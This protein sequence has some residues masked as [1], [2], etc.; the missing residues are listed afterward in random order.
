[1][2]PD[3]GAAGTGLGPEGGA[4]GGPI[5]LFD[6]GAGETAVTDAD[7]TA[8]VPGLYVP[9]PD[10]EGG[11]ITDYTTVAGPTSSTPFPVAPPVDYAVGRVPSSAVAADLNGD[12]KVDLVVGTYFSGIQVLLNSG[13]GAFA[14]P[15]SYAT[16]PA[17]AGALALGD[18][19]GDGKPDIVVADGDLWVFVNDGK[20]SFVTPVA[21]VNR[22]PG[23]ASGFPAVGDFDKDGKAD[24]VVYSGAAAAGAPEQATVLL[25]QGGG[26][27]AMPV[28][29]PLGTSVSG[30]ILAD[31]DGDGCLD[32]VVSNLRDNSVSFGKNACDGSAKLGAPLTWRTGGPASGVAAGVLATRGNLHPD[33]VAS[34]SSIADV[35]VFANYLVGGG[36]TFD[37]NTAVRYN[38]G[39]G[40]RAVA[41]ADVDGDGDQ[42]VVVSL[43]GG[44]GV[45][46]N[47]GD[48][49]FA[50]PRVALS[51]CGSKESVD[52]API[53]LAVADFDGD[54][55]P[56][57]AATSNV[58]GVVTVYLNR[59]K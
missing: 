36:P 15:V 7:T 24:I 11:V 39:G 44:V 2:I 38:A 8:C 58:R 17:H 31:M 57:F 55:R 48:R 23:V 10:L 46:L 21:P 40:A 51:P 54:G 3:T 56:D 20:G 9:Q 25:N 14:A 50:P 32:V 34:L 22:T 29:S 5:V 1:L 43:M 35:N 12:G 28:S 6:A 30:L 45:L 37:L 53:G 41:V 18:L 27:F 42:D 4:A 59:L 16:S 47:N 19:S 33:L 13:G 49:S 26:K 52:L